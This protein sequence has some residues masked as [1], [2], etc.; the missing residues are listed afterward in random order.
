KGKTTTCY[1]IYQFLQN[2]FNKTALVSTTFFAIGENLESNETKM[3]MPGRFF[4]PKFLNRAFVQGA[5]YAVVETT[6]EGILQHRQ[7]FLNYDI[8]VF[9]SLSPEHIE[10]H[11]SF[12]AYREAKERLFEQCKEAHVLN[13]NDEHAKHFLEY[14]AKAKWGI[15][16]DNKIRNYPV[17]NILEGVLLS[18]SGESR[19]SRRAGRD[20]GIQEIHLDSRL[21]GNDNDRCL[22]IKE[23]KIVKGKKKLISRRTIIL[24]FPGKFNAMNL[25]LSLATGRAAGLSLN[26]LIKSISGL[27]LPPGRMQELTDISVPFRIFLDYAHEPL[28]LESVLAAC[29]E[30]LPKDKR[31]ICLTGA[32]GG[33]RDKW[34]RKVMGAVAAKYCDFVIVGTEDPYQEDP[35]KINQ[36]VL[37]GAISNKQFQE[38]INCWKFNE[39]KEAIRKALSLAKN[40]DII[41]LTGKGGEKLMC[42]GNKK[43]PWDEEREVRKIILSS[44][45]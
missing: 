42:A 21:R 20:P 31:L 23:W 27:A 43:I 39:R 15:I 37:A 2:N 22:E 36:A 28:S 9:T 18:S 41:I 5:K 35:E 34:K 7:R 8:A 26:K 29:R 30:Q 40:G 17:Q 45:F 10:R 16:L 13:L 3:G 24:P 19:P 11:G 25:L 33:G 44:K 32:Q 12:S 6:S 38:G 4:L 1:F 14:P